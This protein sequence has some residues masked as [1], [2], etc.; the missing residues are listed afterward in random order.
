MTGQVFSDCLIPAFIDALNEEIA[1]GEITYDVDGIR[2]L[3]QKV[4]QRF[5]GEE[6]MAPIVE[7]YLP[8]FEAWL[9]SSI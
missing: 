6:S 3:C 9:S 5:V 7:T 2:K 4:Q 1:T 8:E